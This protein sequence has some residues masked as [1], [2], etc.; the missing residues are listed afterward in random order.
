MPFRLFYLL[1]CLKHNQMHSLL[2]SLKLENGYCIDA[3][4]AL[5]SV[6]VIEGGKNDVESKWKLYP[7]QQDSKIDSCGN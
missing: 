6:D 2:P 5:F 3:S 7:S 4:S 1:A